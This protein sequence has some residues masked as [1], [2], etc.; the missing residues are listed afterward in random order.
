MGTTMRDLVSVV[1]RYSRYLLLLWLMSAIAIGVFY[2]QAPR[3]YDSKAR[4]LVSLGTE[5]KGRADY[6]NERNMLV[7]QREQQIRN[8]QQILQSHDVLLLT[9]KWILGSPTDKP[10]PAILADRILEAR[11][12]FTGEVPESSMTLRAIAA[13]RDFIGKLFGKSSPSEDREEGLARQ[14]SKSLGVTAIFQSDAVDLS[15]RYRDPRVAQTVLSLILAAYVDHHI[16]IFQNTAEASLLGKE[17]DEA[18]ARLQYD[19]QQLA[20][21]MNSHSIYN[22]DT[23][24]QGLIAQEQKLDETL[25]DARA[26]RQ[27]VVARLKALDT[28]KQSNQPFERY[29]TTEARSNT[30]EELSMK[31]NQ[32]LVEQQN[33][34]TVHPV[35]SRAYQDSEVR[36]NALRHAI[37]QEPPQVVAQT[38][39]RRSN[40]SELIESELVAMS[41]NQKGEDARISQLMEEKARLKSELTD[42]T[43][44]LRGLDALKAQ[45]N[46]TK[47]ESERIGAAYVESH[48]RA[49]TSRSG[50]T[51]ISIIDSPTWNSE[52]ASPKRS[53]V[54]LS[55]SAILVLGSIGMLFAFSHL[56]TTMA[57]G[58]GVARRMGIG[59]TAT[60][61]QMKMNSL[62]S[63]AEH[64]GIVN[65]KQFA[66]IFQT[67][68]VEA[69]PRKVI[70]IAESNSGE[71]ATLVG[72]CLARFIS[73][74]TN[75]TVGL[76]DRTV[77][78]IHA[79]Q[80]HLIDNSSAM[81]TLMRTGDNDGSEHKLALLAEGFARIAQKY[82]YLIVAGGAVKDCPELLSIA[83]I[84]LATFLII[85]A[86][87]TRQAAARNSLELLNSYGFAKVHLIL[88]R[89]MYVVPEW[90]MRYL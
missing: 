83:G 28:L 30:R 87:K 4:V 86:G 25:S 32:A 37:A 84:T 70:L 72:Y 56:D 85:E 75:K 46:F 27:S 8:E 82:D 53:L 76:I 52:A 58:H 7:A 22:D 81:Q 38:E 11:R 26:G 77:H 6:M 21:F 2:W 74:N 65:G 15:F 19:L 64:F 39:Q 18:M 13:S 55:T 54:L 69:S 89:R 14:L 47:Q 35:G 61:P 16:D 71:G 80:D 3:S 67:A 31:L 43:E 60:L 59:L 17:R 33:L 29:S 66:R 90:L 40:A 9:S 24:I 42:Y 34:L 68:Q 1:F 44:G 23:Q 41:E 62:G 12:Y 88:N 10:A 57:D 78:P 50:I 45:L 5:V 49:L 36:I 48:L 79:A 51:D 20:E 73:M 63:F